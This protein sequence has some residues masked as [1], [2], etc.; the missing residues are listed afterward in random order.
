MIDA[1]ADTG[2]NFTENVA[3]ARWRGE[4]KVVLIVASTGASQ[5]SSCPGV[6]AH[7]PCLYSPLT[8]MLF[9]VM[10]ATLKDLSVQNSSGN[11]TSLCSINYV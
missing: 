6:G 3:A 11:V 1:P 8:T 7:I 2:K 5:L 10:F 9:L 4:G